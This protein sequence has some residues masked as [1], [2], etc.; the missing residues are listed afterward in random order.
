[1]ALSVI[2]S[3]QGSTA[4]R[5]RPAGAGTGH[6]QSAATQS[7]PA[8]A[9]PPASFAVGLRVLR[10]IDT[11]RTITLPD[12]S[13]QPR[14][15]VTYVR[16]PALGPAGGAEINGAPPARA[17][18]PY[19]L[20]VFG[21]GFNVTPSLYA[22]LLD[23]WTQAGYIV[24]AP[25]FPLENANAPGGANESDLTNQ[26]ADLHFVIS[27]MLAS[28]SLPA[29]PLAGLADP[30]A[31]AVA[32][33][34]DGGDTALALAYDQRF[35]DP[36]VAAAVI[37]SGAEIPGEE[38][39]SFPAGGPALLAT[40]GTAD[41]INPPNLT[42]TFFGVARRPKFLLRL[43]G[44]AHL[45]PYSSQ[46]PQLSIVERVTLGFLDGYLKRRP[47]A[48]QQL[49]SLGTVPGTASLLAEP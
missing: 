25:L 9:P 44:A 34:S 18:G 29:D 48:L 8:P 43:L 23:R 6:A 15:L 4:A 47:A 42:E 11:S 14:T 17:W 5:H 16:Y 49:V 7:T 22:S 3:S 36:R 31:I 12:G 30:A 39:F 27:R 19:P 45:P 40:Q 33:H 32:G 21:H 20:I 1:V 38:G 13:T 37:L 28:S 24:A 26:P 46:Q 2:L 10:L 41:P 35:R